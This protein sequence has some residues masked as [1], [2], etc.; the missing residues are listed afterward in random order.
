MKYNKTKV[1]PTAQSVVTHQGGDGYQF[2]PE[3]ELMSLLANGIKDTYYEKESEQEKRLVSLVSQVADKD[4]LLVAKMLVYT[5]SESGQRS[6]T[7]RAAVALAPFIS[8]KPWATDFFSKRERNANYGGIVYRID[9]MLEIA[10]CYSAL[11]PGKRLSNSMTRGFRAAFENADAY[12]LAKYKGTDKGVKLIDLLNLVKPVETDRNGYVEVDK[13]KYLNAVKNSKKGYQA[14][15]Y[16]ELEN[17]KLRIPA[18]R[19]LVLGLLEQFNTIEDK[20]SKLGQDVAA[21]VS[22]GALTT[23]Q[24]AVALQKGK[25]EIFT[26]GLTD[27]SFGYAAVIGNLRNLI[28][29]ATTGDSI[30]AAVD[31]L[32]NA[33]GIRKSLIAP[34]KIDLALEVVLADIGPG[35]LATPILSALSKAYELAIPNMSELGAVGTTAVV[36]DSSSSMS[37]RIQIG[38]GVTGSQG[39]IEKAALIAATLAKAFNA[40]V[41]SF[42]ATCRK[43]TYNPLD[44]INTIKNLFNRAPGGDTLFRT[45]FPALQKRYDR[46]FVISDGQGADHL[47]NTV[48]EYR[49]RFGVDPHV[50]SI[51]LCGYNTTMFKPGSKIYQIF[52]YNADIYELISK[53]EVDPQVLLDEV[54]KI[55]ISQRKTSKPAL[56]KEKV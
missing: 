55:N 20:T 45:I 46:V 50:Y 56:Q 21:K 44:T 38:R 47:G 32:T 23:E 40:D 2:K 52:G 18:L 53:M 43:M 15:L 7:H 48:G 17:G 11:N 4:P 25:E 13:T 24:G 51:N 19:A 3:F 14:K 42:D 29:N 8:G 37:T 36:Y 30:N 41:Y 33:V 49:Q 12:E 6:V 35:R 39:A 28:L 16:N 10:A 1:Q 34:H 5:R 54:K 9:D 31:Q 26:K 22:S 27:S